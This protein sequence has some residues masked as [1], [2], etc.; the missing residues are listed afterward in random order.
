V[1]IKR[2]TSRKGYNDENDSLLRPE[3]HVLLIQLPVLPEIS[4]SILRPW[5]KGDLLLRIQ[6]VL[7]FLMI[8]Y[9]G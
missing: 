3:L 2:L 7:A 9:R 5:H 1:G 4:G 8:D 6:I